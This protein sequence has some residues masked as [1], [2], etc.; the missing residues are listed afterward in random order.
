MVADIVAA[1][2]LAELKRVISVRP[3]EVVDELVLRDVAALRE[4]R[5]PVVGAGEVVDALILVK[6][7][8][9]VEGSRRG[10]CRELSYV[11]AERRRKLVRFG[12][13]EYVRL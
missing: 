2:V 1:E 5:S 13:S 4:T 9:V 10:R 8:R 3:R 12:W 11:V 6:R 7:F